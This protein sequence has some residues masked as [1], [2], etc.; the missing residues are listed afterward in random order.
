MRALSTEHGV[1][2]VVAAGNAA[3]DSCGIVPANVP[4]VRQREYRRCMSAW[5]QLEA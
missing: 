1:A 3:S 5:R 2:V 4:E